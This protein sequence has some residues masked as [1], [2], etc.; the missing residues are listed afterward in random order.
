MSYPQLSKDEVRPGC[1]A[2]QGEV[3]CRYLVMG[4]DGFEC[5]RVRESFKRM[6][7]E[8]GDSMRARRSPQE[9]YPLCQ[10]HVV[11]E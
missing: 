7:D 1:G 10:I 4:S 9:E 6:L 3:C 2:G 11:A 5:G 8:R